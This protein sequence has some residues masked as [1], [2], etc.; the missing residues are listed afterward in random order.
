MEGCAVQSAPAGPLSGANTSDAVITPTLD[1]MKD[2]L[3]LDSLALA[4]ALRAG[5]VSPT[6][7]LD[8]T[9][10]AAER[11]GDQVGA[12]VTLS[13]ELARTQA[14]D[15]EAALVAA[16]RTG[17]TAALPP[18][19]GVPCPVKDLSAV[20]G[21]PMRAGS[22]AIDDF[23]PNFD[24]GVAQ[25]LSEAG[26][27]M[28][29]KT[30]TPEF[31]LPCY[32]EPDFG[33]PARTPWDLD[34][35]AGGSS[36]GAAAAVAARIVPAA[37]GSD[38][39][40][41]LRIPA[42]VCGLVGFKTSRGLAG[43]GPYGVDG[44][45]LVSQGVLT[46]TVRD[47]AAFLDVLATPWP[48][49]TF[50]LGDRP[51]SYL[52]SCA[53]PPRPQRIGLLTE[54]VIATGAPVDPAC[55]AAALTTA[56]LLTDLGHEVVEVAPPF[57]AEK[58]APFMALWSV[59]AL[60]APVDPAK[61]HLLTPLTRWLRET[62]RGISA[63]A[64]ADAL[65]GVQRLTREIAATWSAVDVIL[66]P[67]LAQP[68]AKVGALR[69]DSDP[70]ADFAAQMAYTP[71]TSVWNL[72]GWPAVSIPQGWTEGAQPLPIGVMLGAKLGQ[73]ATLLALAAQLEE[74]NPWADR[75]PPV[76]A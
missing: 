45:G 64:Y 70:A 29:G 10:D 19:L 24:D 39:G 9:L 22:A 69:N 28:V 5:E 62:G 55:R 32:T 60:Q 48:G 71:W 74:A 31:G 37:H 40:G 56:R 61:E 14:E 76:H 46:R 25:L 66:S 63:L 18:F 41:S 3:E 13:P 44:P 75:Q 7:V 1:T 17:E 42:S 50:V 15:A 8:V 4:H 11:L 20:A 53:A 49:D 68:P 58:W 65:A 30:S 38:G 54:P 51:D 73:D 16:R 72:A 34:R 35:S 27:V 67:T 52:A 23:V 59:G 57:A 6:E 21:V 26:A 2:L 33:P 36:G 12:F 43:P 47:T